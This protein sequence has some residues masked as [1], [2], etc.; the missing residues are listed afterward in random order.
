MAFHRA[1]PG[2]R[3]RRSKAIARERPVEEVGES[4]GIPGG[5]DG[6]RFVE[7]LGNRESVGRHGDTAATDC[8]EHGDSESLGA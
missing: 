4:F 2:L 6:R 7:H 8:F 3:E 5:K 1:G